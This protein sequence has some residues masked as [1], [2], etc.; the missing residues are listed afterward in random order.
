MKRLFN[1]HT[2]TSYCDGSD[3]PENY[4][5]YA[6]R[7]G[8]HTLG[9]S[10]HAPLPFKNGFAIQNEED[11]KKYCLDIRKL[12][13]EYQHKIDILLALE[14]DYI[15]GTTNG[16]V[17]LKS[18]WGL[19]YTIGSIHLVNNGKDNGRWFID[20]PKVEKYDKG[21]QEFFQGNIKHAV[22][23]FFDST[24]QMI[25]TQKPDIVGHLDKIKMHNKDR[26]FTEDEAW[27]K[28]LWMET[29]ELIHQSGLVVE[30]NT[31]GIYKG[32]C[33]DLYPGI[34]ILRQI[35]Q[36]GIPLTISSDAHRPEEIDGHYTQT[37]QML[38]ELGFRELWYCSSGGWKSQ[39][40]I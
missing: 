39:V 34:D 17:E 16:F 24:N 15:R 37:I 27:Y 5:I 2:H 3:L 20:G 25:L 33:P 40:I 18:K 22:K 1:H 35:K 30:V 36:L 9:F 11:L 26:Y 28:A 21:L 12:Q 6:L 7:A 10:G 23:A 32:R 29:L 8:F 31:R 19:D 38:N 4:A 14:I 13:K